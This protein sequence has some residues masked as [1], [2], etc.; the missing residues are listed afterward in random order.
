MKRREEVSLGCTQTIR[1]HVRLSRS[2]GK[3]VRVTLKKAITTTSNQLEIASAELD[4]RFQSH[5][6]MIDEVRKGHDELLNQLAKNADLHSVS[7]GNHAR[8]QRAEDVLKSTETMLSKCQGM[9]HSEALQDASAA[10]ERLEAAL[11]QVQAGTWT[12]NA[13]SFPHVEAG[14]L[15]RQASSLDAAFNGEM[16]AS[17]SQQCRR[18][19]NPY[20]SN[21]PIEQRMLRAMGIAKVRARSAET[22][23]PATVYESRSIARRAASVNPQDHRRQ[24]SE[25]QQETPHRSLRRRSASRRRSPHTR[26]HLHQPT[27]DTRTHLNQPT[28]A[29]GYLENVI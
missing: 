5:T 19:G 23:S 24:D 7:C 11:A 3:H 12:V 29:Y 8:L 20:E 16:L 25:T 18:I 15:W 17:P 10:A 21:V 6:A 13:G 27:G 26:M 4:R 22:F 14:S 2:N 1:M 28:G 9:L